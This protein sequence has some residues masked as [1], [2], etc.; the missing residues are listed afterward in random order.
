MQ[1]IIEHIE[2]RKEMIQGFLTRALFEV[3]ADFVWI[4]KGRPVLPRGGGG[5]VLL[6]GLCRP[7]LQILTLFQAKKCQFPHSFSVQISK[8]HS[9]FQTWPLGLDWSANKKF[10]KTISNS[11]I[12]LSFL[13]IWNWNDKYVHT[14]RSFLKNNTRSQ[15][16]MGKENTRFDTKTAQKDQKTRWSGTYLYRLYKGVI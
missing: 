3:S 7:V 14:L 13:L 12:F 16:K 4:S 8:I 11:H 15:T 10:F 2:K 1:L 6:V 9:R 5:G